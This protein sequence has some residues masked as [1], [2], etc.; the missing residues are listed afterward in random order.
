MHKPVFPHH[1][2]K[3]AAPVFLSDAASFLVPEYPLSLL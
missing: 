2:L 3:K 1:M